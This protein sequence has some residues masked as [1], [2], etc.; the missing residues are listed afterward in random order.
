VCEEQ[1]HWRELTYLYIAYDEY[2]NAAATMIAHSPIAW[3]H[4]QFKD[5]CVKVSNSEVSLDWYRIRSSG[6]VWL[7]RGL[8][9][10]LLLGVRPGVRPSLQVYYRALSFYL[11]E[12]PDLLVDLMGVLTPRLDHARVVEQFRWVV[13]VITAGCV[14]LR[15]IVKLLPSSCVCPWCPLVQAGRAAPSHQGLPH[16]CAEDQHPGGGQTSCHM[17]SFG[18]L[19]PCC[20]FMLARHT[21]PVLYNSVSHVPLHQVNEAVNGLLIEE[22]DFEGLR[23]SISHYDNFDQLGLAAKLEK[24]ELLEF[25]CVCRTTHRKCCS[26]AVN[27]PAGWL[28]QAARVWQAVSACPLPSST[29]C[30]HGCSQACISNLVQEE[31]QVAQG[32]GPCQGRQAVQGCHGDHSRVRGPGRREACG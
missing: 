2:D 14:K 7:E 30:T 8:I 28:L 21:T 6:C 24:H 16:L 18:I 27:Q 23:H 19:H 25:R 15:R 3:E 17:P 4:V 11:E 20:A 31:P 13:P 32:S 12:H 22:E 9:Q 26:D 29:S 10:A 5:V 1:Q